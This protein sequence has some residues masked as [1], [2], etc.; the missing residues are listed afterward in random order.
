LVLLFA[1]LLLGWKNYRDIAA[2]HEA[3]KAETRE[4]WLKQGE[5]NPHSAAHYAVYAFKPKLLLSLADRGVDPYTG[6]AAWL[7]A[8]KQNEFRHK[9]AQDSTAVQRFGELTAATVLQL[10]VPLLIVLLSFSAFAGEREQGTLRQLMSLGVSKR[11]LVLGKGLGIAVSLALLIVPATVLGIAALALTSSAGALAASLPRM[12]LMAAGYLLYF[13][14]FAGIS[15]G[16]SALAGS[17]RL[18]LVVLIGFWIVNGL[19]A[20]RVTA[21]VAKT[22]YPTPSA[23]QFAHAIANDMEHG[24]DGHNPQ[25]KRAEELKQSVLRQYRVTKLEDLPVSFAG[26]SLQESEEY[27][28]Q[29]F[30]R[31]YGA[32]WATF[33]RQNRL[34]Q[35]AGVV[36]PALAVRSVSMGAAGTDFAQ[37]R[38]F[39]AA[40]ESY[41]RMLVKRMNDDMTFNAG[42]ADYDYKA[43]ADLWRQV[44]DFNYTAQSG[45]VVF[46]RQWPSLLALLLWFT[47]ASVFA[48][49]AGKKATV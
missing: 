34:K 31:H 6:V 16:A 2:Q 36:A 43:G 14:I 39:A 33:E 25:D 3:A 17:S 41:R 47:A 23:F 11:D 12:L 21:D 7:E 27:G 8:H 44:P 37:H 19:V 20:P 24:L 5:K 45:R 30:D 40:A 15:L 13:G 35:L 42:K 49:V 32:L 28:N 4:Q 10:L 22:V 46:G 26:I 29:V 1:S 48:I 9:P 38:D 18:A